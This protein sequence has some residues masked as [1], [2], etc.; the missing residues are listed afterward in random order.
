MG[1]FPRFKR[2][3]LHACVDTVLAKHVF[4]AGFKWKVNYNVKY[5]HIRNG[6]SDGFVISIG[7]V[8]YILLW[9]LTLKV[10]MQVLEDF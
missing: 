1:G 7:T 3:E 5:L 6:L 4:D 9:I 8:H 10:N 2:R